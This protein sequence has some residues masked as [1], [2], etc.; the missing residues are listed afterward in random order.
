[1]GGKLFGFLGFLGKKKR[2]RSDL[3]SL[4]AAL[5]SG[6]GEA[7]G[8]A[9]ARTLL[10]T[11]AAL[12][13]EEKLAFLLTLEDRFG[14]DEARLRRAI[15]AYQAA[16]DPRTALALH[17]AAEPPRQELIRR[18]NRAAGGTTGLVRMRED[19]LRNLAKHP[20]LDAL[21][22]DFVHLFSSWFNPGFLVLKRI[23]WSTPADLLEKIIRY[24]AVHEIKS[25]SDL[26]RRLEP[27]DRRCFA[28]FHP[29]LDDDPLVFVEVALTHDVPASIA[30]LLAE[31]RP[32]RTSRATTAVFYSISNCQPGLR[33]VSLGNF[34]I[35]QVVEE[36]M[37]ELPRLKTFVT[38]SPVPGFAKWLRRE[39]ESKTSRLLG[40]AERSALRALDQPGWQ[41]HPQTT[42]TLRP[43][44][45]DAIAHYFLLARE[46]SGK[47]VDPV[48]KF[49]LGNGARLERINWMG[50][51]SPKGISEAAGFM[52]NYLYDLSR[53]ERNH[54]AFANKGEVVASG[55]VRK[56]LGE[57]T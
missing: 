46:A 36:L 33:G 34:L 57:K 8:R 52:V 38:L 47:P 1:V 30:P 49:H 4:A 5:L 10:A 41:G 13:P 6:R 12:D 20:M 7:S 23:D 11:Y 50:D 35:K 18:L 24:E 51:P 19:V 3:A 28:F 16:P 45:T 21:D 55:A 53:I 31:A 25:W 43:V 14:A 40:A 54:E 9:M 37:R 29:A 15:E 39:R 2:V 27:G 22:V 32:G 44:L 48:A 26:R 56:L 17:D 42:R